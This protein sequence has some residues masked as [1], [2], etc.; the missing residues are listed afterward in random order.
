MMNQMGIC[1]V[2]LLFSFLIF[3]IIYIYIYIYRRLVEKYIA[4]FPVRVVGLAFLSD[5]WKTNSGAVM[6]FV[7]AIQSLFPLCQLS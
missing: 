2:Q 3:N 5:L 4:C 6:K 1:L 7:I